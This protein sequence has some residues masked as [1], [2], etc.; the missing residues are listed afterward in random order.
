MV[1]DTADRLM[2]GTT[3]QLTCR[4]HHAGERIERRPVPRTGGSENADRQLAQR[5]GDVHE[6]G[7]VGDDGLC[8]RQRENGIAQIGPGE[9]ADMRG[10]GG[11][12]LIREWLFVRSA[13]HPNRLTCCH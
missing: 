11:H 1:S 3:R 9:F 10:I 5:R 4:V 7:I 13:E 12:N 2:A 6:A 8:G